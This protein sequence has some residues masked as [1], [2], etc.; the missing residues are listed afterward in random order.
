MECERLILLLMFEYFYVSERGRELSG[1]VSGQ[2][3]LLFITGFFWMEDHQDQGQGPPVI[4]TSRKGTQKTA[5]KRS[6]NSWAKF[7]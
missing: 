7:R 5:L 3:S 4:Q 6:Q 2:W 1:L